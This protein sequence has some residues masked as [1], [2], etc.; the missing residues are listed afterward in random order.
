ML[1]N[2]QIQEAIV[3]YLKTK[4]DITDELKDGAD[5]IRE[6]EWQGRDF[7]Y[8]NVRVRLISNE[9]QQMQCDLHSVLFSCMAFSE[10]ASSQQADRI[11]GIINNTLHDQSFQSNNI[12]FNA[13]TTSLVPAIRI[14][15]RTWRAETILEASVSG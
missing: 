1:R 5:E 7:T 4:S 11:A 3:S 6:D 8:A 13:R 2:D 10:E 12:S 14:D 15:E 9:P